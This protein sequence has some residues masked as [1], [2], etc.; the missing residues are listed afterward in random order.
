MYWK[1]KPWSIVFFLIIWCMW[2]ATDRIGQVLTE[3][4]CS[5]VMFWI[6]CGIQFL[7]KK[8]VSYWENNK[9]SLDDD[10]S[11]AAWGLWT[12]T[13]ERNLWP[14]V[15]WW[16]CPCL[17]HFTCAYILENVMR[18]TR[19]ISS[20]VTNTGLS[21]NAQCY[22]SF[23]ILAKLRSVVGLTVIQQLTVKLKLNT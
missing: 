1:N 3:N 20:G 2:K 22:L 8:D 11:K 13:Q 16:T 14:S 19:N 5:H 7:M 12:N 4:K 15:C 6:L 18:L 21:L 10:S 23:Q 9:W 17:I